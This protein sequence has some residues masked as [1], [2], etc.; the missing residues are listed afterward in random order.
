MPILP[1]ILHSTPTR[2]I[3]L[4]STKLALTLALASG[5]SGGLFAEALDSAS[6]APSSFRP[7]EFAEEL[8]L[9]RFVAQGLR[10]RI[11]GRQ[12]VMHARH[13]FRL[14]S[15][16]PAD[17]DIVQF[18]RNILTELVGSP[19]LRGALEELY[20]DLCKLR[21]L[22]ENPSGVR[23]WDANRRRLDILQVFK[24]LLDRM[25]SSFVHAS[26][27]LRR[28]SE[29]GAEVCASEPYQALT[30]LLKCDARLASIDVR[31]AVGADGSVNGFEVLAVKESLDNPFVNPVWRRWLAKLELFVRGYRFSDGEILARLV[32][33]VV[34][35]LE[36]ELVSMV[37]LLGDLEFYL[38]AL[39]FRDSA[40]AAGLSV[41]MPEFLPASEPRE[42]RGLYN[43]LLLMSGVVPVPSD[44]LSEHLASTSLITGPNSGGKTRLL[45]SIG[46]TQLMA[47]SGMFAPARTARIAWSSG[48]VASLIEEAKADQ[49][50]GR[51][52]MELVRIRGLFERL[53]PGALVLLDELC[54][55]TNPSEGEQIFE[56]VVTMLGQLEPQAFI[57][58]HFLEFAK[59]LQ[60]E[61]KIPSLD[62]I[63]VELD[64]QRRPTY[65]F[66]PGVADSSLA[67]HTA[68]RLGVT[69]EQLSALIQQNLRVRQ[70][71]GE[72][73]Q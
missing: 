69:G 17:A 50:E 51:L 3:D 59:R 28:L 48:L 61:R 52:G 9:Q 22:L 30:D 15:Q 41:C 43:P 49:A 8:F 25:A 63:R 37:Q 20:V 21:G 6:F 33:A 47:Q 29:F 44:I 23:V 16:P 56:L 27:G 34:S 67:A 13:L 40:I 2:R 18:R 1:D 39:G 26:S 7:A 58:T 53:P 60:R 64:P 5:S 66:L 35:G 32:D 19:G 4:E 45:Q 73:N 14:V 10:A 68:E 46:L 71:G 62:F 11:G 70:L 12:P 65:Q 31:V 57:T 55:G 54:S 36:D 38:G 72:V 24:A 42:L